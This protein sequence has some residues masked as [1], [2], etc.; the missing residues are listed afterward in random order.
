MSEHK[1][2]AAETTVEVI[3]LLITLTDIPQVAC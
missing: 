2:F 3:K 1:K